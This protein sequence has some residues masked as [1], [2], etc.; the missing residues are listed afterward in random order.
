MR[1]EYMSDSNTS[2]DKYTKY[3]FWAT[4]VSWVLALGWYI[5]IGCNFKSL[6]V[7]IAIIETAADW[8]ADTK[9]IIL[10]PTA[11]FVLGIL[12]FVGWIVSLAG[13]SSLG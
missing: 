2:N 11:F 9:R 13:V 12:L 5:F 7:S 3:L 4:I 6:K 8:F 1:S 10:V